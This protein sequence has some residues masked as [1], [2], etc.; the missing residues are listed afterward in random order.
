MCTR[1][2]DY[3]H[4][5]AI[6]NMQL[7]F[8]THVRKSTCEQ[9]NAHRHACARAHIYAHSHMHALP[10]SPICMLSLVVS[11]LRIC[12]QATINPFP[13]EY[14]SIQKPGK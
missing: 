11:H 10:P 4:V 3:T 13:P 5:H 9:P 14:Q 6:V 8:S 7:K 1:A 12:L 2:H